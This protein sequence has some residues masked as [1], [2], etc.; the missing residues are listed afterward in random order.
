[1]MSEGTP[2]IRFWLLLTDTTTVE[3]W[4]TRSTR[5]FIVSR[6]RHRPTGTLLFVAL[7]EYKN[8]KVRGEKQNKGNEKTGGDRTIC[9]AC[10][11]E[12]YQG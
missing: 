3:L 8:S 12:P 5:F 9:Q 7:T 10:T 4:P 6:M 11:T 1:M 2:G